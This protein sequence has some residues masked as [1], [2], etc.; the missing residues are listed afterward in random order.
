MDRNYATF[1]IVGV[2]CLFAYFGYVKHV[3]GQVQI[4]KAQ[5][6]SCPKN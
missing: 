5:A 3:E 2:I 6:A 4:A 1:A